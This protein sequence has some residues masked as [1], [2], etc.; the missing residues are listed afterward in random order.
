M[1]IR[2][3]Y[4]D[5]GNVLFDVDHTQAWQQTL[6]LCSGEAAAIMER[7]YGWGDVISHMIGELDDVSFF[8]SMKDLLGFEAPA[9]TLQGCWTQ[10]FQ[11]IPERWEQVRQL[12]AHFPVGALSNISP[13]HSR[14]VEH[15]IPDLLQFEHR[16]YSWKVGYVKPREEIFHT[17]RQACGFPPSEILFIDDQPR[18]VDAARSLGWQALCLSR[19]EDLLTKVNAHMEGTRS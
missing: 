7:F 10:V 3:I 19:G 9:S 6:P 11:P 12:Q 16:I 13:C 18:H 5:L 17:A 15:C 8:V 2:F 4:F 14:W 1:A